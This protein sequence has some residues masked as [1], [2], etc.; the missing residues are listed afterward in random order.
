MELIALA[1]PLPLGRILDAL[2]DLPEQVSLHRRPAPVQRIAVETRTL[3]GAAELRDA[4][5]QACAAGAELVIVVGAK[6][7]LPELGPTDTPVMAVRA[8][9]TPA[10][11]SRLVKQLKYDSPVP[12]I[13]E[14]EQ[15]QSEIV[16]I[17]DRAADSLRGHIIVEDQD[18][19]MLA[20][21]RF[22]APIDEARRNAI[23]QR[24]M[25][26]YLQ[27][28]FNAQG[29]Q[30]SLIRGEDV[31]E[32]APDAAA[33]L[34][35]RLVVA[36]RSRGRLVGT[37]WFAR[38]SPA[39]AEDDTATLQAAAAQMSEI[40]VADLRR[41]E[42]ERIT[43][44]DAAL[45]L[46]AGRRVEAAL[47]ELG[48]TGR[49][50]G[51]GAHVIS[52]TVAPEHPEAQSIR[53]ADFR[54]LVANSSW[55]VQNEAVTVA[56]GDRLH[57]VHFDCGGDPHECDATGARLLAGYFV[58]SLQRVD[59]EVAVG[60]GSHANAP[61]DVAGSAAT[62]DRV[63]NALLREG[64]SGVATPGE[65]WAPLLLDQ[66][67]AQQLPI[68]GR[69]PRGLEQML[70]SNVAKDRDLLATVRVAIDHWGDIGRAARR[71][72]VHHNTVRY[73]LQRFADLTGV[74]LDIP[75]MRFAVWALLRQPET[76][77]AIAP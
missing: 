72:H 44:D 56:D 51:R 47:L 65:F 8:E 50:F 59:I 27:Q 38:A 19:Q 11:I 30:A 16:D 14:D 52:F 76:A 28:V 77:P 32:V 36:I 41:R 67:L 10:S 54:V 53:L 42:D 18:F 3:A 45:D 23:M 68:R 63:L 20:Y 7:L 34:G 13:L 64:R 24:R 58:E 71:L 62:A 9:A 33:G 37:I 66:L 75:D 12:G 70:A 46:L 73:R 31:L 60:I 48:V 49:S 74:D 29:V 69:V 40:L 21:S 25:P 17:V 39:F 43:R 61:H 22:A 26:G 35:P 5:G 55:S 57:I 4:Y 15:A 2:E 1:T 6:P